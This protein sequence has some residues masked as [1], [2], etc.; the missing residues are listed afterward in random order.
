MEYLKLKESDQF[1]KFKRKMKRENLI[2][3]ELLLLIREW[4]EEF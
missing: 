3:W 1:L 4:M 2:F